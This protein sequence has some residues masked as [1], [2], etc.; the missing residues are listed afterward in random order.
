MPDAEFGARPAA[1]LRT[2]DGSLPDAGALD[3]FLRLTLPG[4]KVPVRYLRVAGRRGGDEAGPARAWRRWRA[5]RA[6][7]S[8]RLSVPSQVRAR[9]RRAPRS[10]SGQDAPVAAA[11]D[12][13]TVITLPASLPSARSRR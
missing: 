11:T 10:G 4:F 7:V 12:A 9:T 5:T 2:A 3:R 8:A 13:C 1:F 6:A